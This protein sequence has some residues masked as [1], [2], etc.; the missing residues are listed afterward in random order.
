MAWRSCSRCGLSGIEEEAGRCPRC[1]N[2]NLIASDISFGAY[3]FCEVIMCALLITVLSLSEP[4]NKRIIPNSFDG[5]A[6]LPANNL[7]NGPPWPLAPFPNAADLEA[8]EFAPH[9]K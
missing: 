1:G 3:V 2:T 9:P 8:K 4:R 7:R 5:A 6:H